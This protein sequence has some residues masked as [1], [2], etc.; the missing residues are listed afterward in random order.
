VTF[1]QQI[2]EV[3]KIKGQTL[4]YKEPDL[5]LC[6]KQNAMVSG[7]SSGQKEEISISGG[8]KCPRTK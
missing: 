7:P 5:L 4:L 1:A 8:Q 3:L 6:Q 2:Y